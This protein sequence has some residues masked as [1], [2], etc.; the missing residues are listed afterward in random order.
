MKINFDEYVIKS[1]MFLK[2]IFFFEQVLK[3]NL[4]NFRKKL[5]NQSCTKT[6]TGN[7]V[8]ITKVSKILNLKEL[9]KIFL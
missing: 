5:Y 1:Y 4:K 9:G 6:N 8:N 3:I 2:F 7:Y